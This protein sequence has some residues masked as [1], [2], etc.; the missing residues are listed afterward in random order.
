MEPQIIDFYNEMPSCVNVIEKMNEEFSNIQKENEELKKKL[1]IKLKI[2][3]TLKELKDIRVIS[4]ELIYSNKEDFDND[5]SQEYLKLKERINKMHVDLSDLDIMYPDLMVTISDTLCNFIKDKLHKY[6]PWYY[7]ISFELYYHINYTVIPLNKLT[8]CN[9][10]D[11][12]YEIVRSHIDNILW[13]ESGDGVVRFR[14][15]KCGYDYIY[16]TCC[17]CRDSESSEEFE[18]D[19]DY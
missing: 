7:N 14:C 1:K 10:Q 17:G 5:K 4:P 8:G 15:Q 3:E 16:P 6:R 2:N 12:I 18:E 11:L 13:N 19:Y 9:I